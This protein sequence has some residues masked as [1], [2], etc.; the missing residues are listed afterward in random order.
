MMN[1]AVNYRDAG[2]LPEAVALLED[3]LLRARKLPGPAPANLAWI[4]RVLA[5]T[6]DQ[7]GQF[8]RSEPLHRAFLDRVRRQLGP[9]HPQTAGALA[10]L[11]L[12]LLRQE[13]PADAEP[14]L[15][16]CLAVREKKEP[17]AWTTFNTKSLLGGALL[18]QKKYADAEPLLLAGYEGLKRRQAGLP[19]PLRSTR[20]SE[21]L[22]RLVRLHEARGQEGEAAKWRKELEAVKTPRPARQPKEK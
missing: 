22:Q 9:D 3:A 5:M 14:P 1:L 7:A 6:Y 2:R 8:A 12:N 10:E 16:E 21:A 18:G 4:P 17:D 19:E 15:R 20:L 13:K 11:G